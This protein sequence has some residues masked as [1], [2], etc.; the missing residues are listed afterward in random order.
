MIVIFYQ[1]KNN[2]LMQHIMFAGGQKVRLLSLYRTS[3]VIIQLASFF[4][5]DMFICE[6]KQML[7]HSCAL[8]FIL[9]GF[10]SFPSYRIS[11]IIPCMLINPHRKNQSVVNQTVPRLMRIVQNEVHIQHREISNQIFCFTTFKP[12]RCPG[13][14]FAK[15]FYI[16]RCS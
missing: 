3:F 13:P 1:E 4:S 14:I 8:I 5:H 12:T 9:P 11:L 7:Y 2:V 6:L 10:I 15:L 16:V